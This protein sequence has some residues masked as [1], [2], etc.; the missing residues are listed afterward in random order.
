MSPRLA[1]V[2]Y[3]VSCVLIALG[4]LFAPLFAG[5][6]L[7]NRSTSWIYVPGATYAEWLVVTVAMALVGLAGGGLTRQPALRALR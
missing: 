1:V 7:E 5:A 3:F 4:F 6:A 2:A